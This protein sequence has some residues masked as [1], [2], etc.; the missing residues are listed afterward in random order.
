[1]E[2]NL[3]WLNRKQV[4]Q[5]SL[6]YK[7]STI[8]IDKKSPIYAVEYGDSDH[9]LQNYQEERKENIIARK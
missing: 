8:G 2:S 4:G 7:K 9:V 3:N 5:T 6:Q 1:M